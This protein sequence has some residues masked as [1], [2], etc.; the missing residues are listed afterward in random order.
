[1]PEDNQQPEEGEFKVI[2]KWR[3][4][5]SLVQRRDGTYAICRYY[6]KEGRWREVLYFNDAESIDEFLDA[7][8][9]AHCIITGKDLNK[10]EEA[11]CPS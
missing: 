1:M 3:K 7:M 4:A 10:D 9:E 6:P 2:K 11:A 8:D 5:V